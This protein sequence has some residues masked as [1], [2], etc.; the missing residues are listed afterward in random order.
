MPGSDLILK[1]RDVRHELLLCNTK[2]FRQA[3]L[4]CSLLY[5]C[6]ILQ[7]HWAMVKE[8]M[9]YMHGYLHASAQV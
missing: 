1:K 9:L 8:G 7:L 4:Q 2:F 5:T 6:T 3:S